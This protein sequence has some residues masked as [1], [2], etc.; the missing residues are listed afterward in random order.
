MMSGSGPDLGQ[1]APAEFGRDQ[2]HEVV[3][4]LAVFVMLEFIGKL[5]PQFA[6]LGKKRVGE[7]P[8][9]YLFRCADDIAGEER[10]PLS[11]RRKRPLVTTGGIIAVPGAAAP[12]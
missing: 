1:R 3:E 5:E 10:A 8:L 7:Q 2:G 11:L 9:Q 6:D 4:D 12:G